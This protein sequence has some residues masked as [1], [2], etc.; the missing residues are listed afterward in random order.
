MALGFL[1]PQ[2]NPE[3]TTGNIV[4]NIGIFLIILASVISI[5]AKF[6]KAAE[7]LRILKE[8]KERE[9]AKKETQ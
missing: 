9:T 1:N 4:A 3:G 7:I 8:V 5:V 2:I 6:N